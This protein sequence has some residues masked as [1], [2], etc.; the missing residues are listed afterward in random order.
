MSF[1]PKGWRAFLTSSYP[2]GIVIPNELKCVSKH[3][4]IFTCIRQANGKYTEFFV[5]ATAPHFTPD[6]EEIRQYARLRLNHE[7]KQ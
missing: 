3:G 2:A 7:N 6:L 4:A 1:V 5:E